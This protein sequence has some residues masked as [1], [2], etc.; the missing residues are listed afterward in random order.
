MTESN[1]QDAEVK[2]SVEVDDD[3]EQVDSST[4]EPIVTAGDEAKKSDCGENLDDEKKDEKDDT[5][6]AT[7]TPVKKKSSSRKRAQPKGSAG[8]SPRSSK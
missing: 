2:P 8:K 7:S 4:N 6:A 1:L 5:E 3:N